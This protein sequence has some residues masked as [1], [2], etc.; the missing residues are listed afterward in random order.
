MGTSGRRAPGRPAKR[1][2]RRRRRKPKGLSSRR[3][4][5][6]LELLAGGVLVATASL[7][8]LARLAGEVRPLA[9][10]AALG[11]VA[12]V[13]V[14]VVVG[15]D[16][17]RAARDGWMRHLLNL[18]ALAGI[19]AI[20]WFAPPNH[21][22][23]ALRE[24]LAGE[25]M[26]EIRV[27]RHQVYAAYRRMNLDDQVLIL[28]RSRVFE[29]TVHEAAAAF[30]EDPEVLMGV[31]A[32]ES[33]F[34]PRPSRDGGRGLFQITAIPEE[35]AAAAREKLGVARLDPINQRH[36]AYA[37]AA[38]LARYR[39]QMN[40]DLFLTLLA[41]NIGPHNGGLA[42][43]MEKYGASNFAQAQ[44][45]LRE[46]PRDYPIRVLSS[47]LA[48]RVWRQLGQLPRYQEGERATEI[49]ALG[50]PGLDEPSLLSRFL[51]NPP[52]N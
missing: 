10:L 11:S 22:L 30:G 29:P 35:A 39:E 44:P 52:A 23:E 27:V 14:F 38:T 40:G 48:Y 50:V 6:A 9:L 26:T 43:V 36:N 5:R 2:A 12:V 16:R 31:A 7:A 45:Y 41:Y 24:V 18:L 17:V 33:S 47:A 21:A 28:E 51:A 34:H 8:V 15:L 37:A 4:Y 25:R 46:L 32:T 49:Q 1:K 20:T 42:F 3:S 19:V 13:S